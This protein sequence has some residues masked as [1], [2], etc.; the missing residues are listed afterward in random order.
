MSVKSCDKRRDV[1]DDD[2]DE[3]VG[4]SVGDDRNG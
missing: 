2:G 4:I 1:S 3:R